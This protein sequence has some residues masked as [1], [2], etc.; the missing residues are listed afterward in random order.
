M[1]HG[2][3]REQRED[4]ELAEVQEQVE[5][6]MQVPAAQAQEALSKAAKYLDLK[7][8]SLGAKVTSREGGLATGVEYTASGKTE[9]GGIKL[10]T[11]ANTKGEVQIIVYEVGGQSFDTHALLKLDLSD[12]AL[13]RGT[14]E[15]WVHRAQILKERFLAMEKPKDRVPRD[16]FNWSEEKYEIHRQISALVMP[17][18][19]TPSQI[20][21]LEPLLDKFEATR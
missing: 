10:A 6:G 9:F 15:S 4:R 16:P 5:G 18:P 13:S 20:E 1:E 2:D 12:P 3:L 8:L 17:G 7:V 19:F 11:R 21:Q 14:L